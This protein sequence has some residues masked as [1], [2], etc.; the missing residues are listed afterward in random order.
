MRAAVTRS[1]EEGL[2]RAGGSFSTAEKW[3]ASFPAL[4]ESREEKGSALPPPCGMAGCAWRTSALWE[5]P[6][7]LGVRLP[8]HPHPAILLPEGTALP[9]L[10][11][12]CW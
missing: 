6:R 12:G 1:S 5:G 4:H 7:H 10:G 9:A 3:L 11:P 2:V 8:L